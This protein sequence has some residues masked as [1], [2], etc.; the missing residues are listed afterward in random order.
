MRRGLLRLI[1]RTA[2]LNVQAGRAEQIDTPELRDV[3]A[4]L[5]AL[6]VEGIMEGDALLTHYDGNTLFT[7]YEYVGIDGVTFSD[8]W[9]SYPLILS[10]SRDMPAPLPVECAV[11][12]INPDSAHVP[13]AVAFLEA[14]FA[15]LSVDQLAMLFPDL[16]APVYDDAGYRLSLESTLADIE[17]LRQ[18][19]A[20]GDADAQALQARLDSAEA[21][22]E[23]MRDHFWVI[24]AQ[25]LSWYRAHDAGL[26]LEGTSVLSSRETYDLINQYMDGRIS[27]DGLVR[28]LDQKEKME[29]LEAGY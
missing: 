5:E 18:E 11:A 4:A 26:L 1:L 8:R 7:P 25:R 20:R 19:I 21:W 22:L 15:Q 27:L 14:A 24:S 12:F 29:R 17:L 2:L 9:S 13:E 3:L 28:T 6:D 10:L 23:E 16:D